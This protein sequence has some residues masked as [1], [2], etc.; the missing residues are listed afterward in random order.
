VRVTE[1]FLYCKRLYSELGFNPEHVVNVHVRHAG[2]KGRTLAAADP[3]RWVRGAASSIQDQSEVALNVRL[4]RID[5]ELWQLVKKV[6]EPLFALF[7]FFEFEDA[8]YQQI[9]EKFARSET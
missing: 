3:G 2:L 8:I 6:L 1:V 9:V 7:D 4:D 5:A